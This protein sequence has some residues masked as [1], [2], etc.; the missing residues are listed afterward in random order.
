MTGWTIAL[1]VVVALAVAGLMMWAWTSSAKK[2]PSDETLRHPRPE[3]AEPVIR[4]ES[5]HRD[6]PGAADLE[7]RGGREHE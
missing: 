6:T 2:V 4:A 5:K 3:A 1:L 7:T